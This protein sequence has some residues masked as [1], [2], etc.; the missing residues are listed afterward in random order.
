[1][2]L[3]SVTEENKAFVLQISRPACWELQ[4][5]LNPECLDAVYS[6]EEKVLLSVNG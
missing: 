2:H 3:S 6:L 4:S 5:L 1:M